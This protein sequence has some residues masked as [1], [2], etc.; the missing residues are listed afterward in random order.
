LG[1][2]KTRPARVHSGG[3][4]LRMSVLVERSMGELNEERMPVY[5]LFQKGASMLIDPQKLTRRRSGV[6]GNLNVPSTIGTF[7]LDFQFFR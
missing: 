3:E 4:Y 5:P 6:S 2:W 7:S 1:G